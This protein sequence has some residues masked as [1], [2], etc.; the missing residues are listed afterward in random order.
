MRS[1]QDS[2]PIRLAHI[3]FVLWVV[4]SVGWALFAAKLAL[5]KGWWVQRPM[6]GAALVLAPPALA[7]LLAKVI[8]KMTDNPKF[9]N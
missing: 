7:H 2:F 5:D 1:G 6:M 3:L 9:R 8:I 4:G